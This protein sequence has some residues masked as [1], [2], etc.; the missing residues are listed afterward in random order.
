MN[1]KQ[2]AAIL[3]E[4]KHLIE[5]DSKGKRGVLRD[6]QPRIGES[7]AGYI[8]RLE[9]FLRTVDDLSPAEKRS[10]SIIIPKGDHRQ[11]PMSWITYLQEK[12]GTADKALPTGNGNDGIPW[13]T[14][15]SSGLAK[16]REHAKAQAAYGEGEILKEIYVGILRGEADLDPKTEEWVDENFNIS[17]KGG[18]YTIEQKPAPAG[19]LDSEI[20]PTDD[21]NTRLLLIKGEDGRILNQI[22]IGPEL[23]ALTEKDISVVEKKSGDE[24]LVVI[25]DTRTNK[26]IS[27]YRTKDVKD[28]RMST[29]FG[30]AMQRGREQG[31]PEGRL[32]VASTTVDGKQYFY[33]VI[34]PKSA[35]DPTLGP[36]G[37]DPK[38]KTID[39]GEGQ[40]HILMYEAGGKIGSIHVPPVPG[41]TIQNT[42]STPGG[43]VR[44]IFSD[45]EEE[46]YGAEDFTIG[47]PVKRRDDWWIETSPGEYKKIPKTYEPG[48]LEVGG[49]NL[50]QQRTGEYDLLGLPEVPAEMEQVSVGGTDFPFIRG[51]QG[52]LTPFQPSIDNIITQALIDGNFDKALAF[53]D[54]KNRPSAK[55]AFDAALSFARS[56]ADQQLISSIARGETQ[57]QP[58]DPGT[59]RRV[60]PQPDFLIQAYNEF[61]QRLRGGRPPTPEEQQDYS[62]RFS[63]GESPESDQLKLEYAKLE[64]KNREIEQKYELELTRE[65]NRR[66]EIQDKYNLELNKLNGAGQP[67]NGGTFTPVGDDNGGDGNG[68]EDADETKEVV[69]PSR[70]ALIEAARAD[71][72][73]NGIDPK[74]VSD[75]IA[76]G[77]VAFQSTEEIVAGVKALWEPFLDTGDAGDITGGDI[78]GGDITG[79]DLPGA[80]VTGEAVTGEEVGVQAPL[81]LEQSLQAWQEKQEPISYPAE[82]DWTEY[83]WIDEMAGGGL[84]RGKN[85]EI[86]GEEGPELVDLPPGTFVLPLKGLSQREVRRAKSKGTKGYQSGGVVFPDLPFGLRQLQSG[87]AI[88]PPRGYLSRAAGLT[89]PSA[90]AFQNIT[91]ESREVFADLASRAGIPK[92]AFAQ[93]LQTAFPGGRRLPVSRTYPLNLRGVR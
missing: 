19:D 10:I 28:P 93:E 66:Q 49:F 45:G 67:A 1:P 7:V 6:V 71:A 58:P 68:D 40:G 83:G 44:V 50:F 41:R 63:R 76:R 81:S 26:I 42:F 17:R 59:I 73:A 16:T 75:A 57:I 65:Q 21:P 51:T 86:V 56:P 4:I 12:Y 38:T 37:E 48:L 3:A 82:E 14:L 62:S 2:Q 18:G 8:T 39:L 87:R 34:K 92:G 35:A 47:E 36:E 27:Q 11:D 88:T 22:N 9:Q 90:Q 91:P 25:T 29:T 5:E 77:Q 32:D 31:I 85:L 33:P 72:I 80:A 64:Q 24:N 15:T 79:G 60:G 89:L 52:E 54:F 55:E 78:T 23:E 13:D 43:G 84:T 61:Q 46:I 53:Q 74:I 69:E 20:F 70:A 30:A